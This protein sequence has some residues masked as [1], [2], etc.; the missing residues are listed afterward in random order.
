MKKNI[1]VIAN[2]KNYS[3]FIAEKLKIFFDEFAAFHCY[4]TGEI[5]AMEQLEEDYVVLSAFTIF[6]VAKKK[7]KETARLIIV[8]L[9]L[10]KETLG[11][12]YKVPNH[13]RALLVNIDYRNCMEAITMIYNL[14]YRHLELIPYFPGCEY[15]ESVQI[16]V[17]PGGSGPGAGKGIHGHRSG[18][19]APGCE[20]HLQSGQS[21]RGGESIPQ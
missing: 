18:T 7:V 17:T 15:D 9:T 4:G 10:N 13:A 11:R 21:H 14:G 5:V 8:D 19:A 6:Q 12:L 3:E 1:A 20:F 16:A 2:N